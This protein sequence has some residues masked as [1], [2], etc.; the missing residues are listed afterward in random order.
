VFVGFDTPRTL[1]PRETG[2]SVAVPVFKAFMAEALADQPPVPFRIPRGIRMVRI[3]GDTGTVPAAT[4]E[5]IIVEAFK[6]GTEPGKA[7]AAVISGDGVLGTDPGAREAL[8]AF[9]SGLY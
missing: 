5:R 1:G 9:D 7:T 3:D 6:P 4:S 8:S 2:S